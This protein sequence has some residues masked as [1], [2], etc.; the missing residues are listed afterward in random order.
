MKRP[1]LW[2]EA[3]RDDYLGII[4]FIAQENPD[5]AERVADGID[6]AILRLG[7]M[8]VGR[9]GRV[10]GTYEKVVAGLPYI[11]AY[12]IVAQPDGGEMIAVLH[13]IHGARNWPKGEWPEP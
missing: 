9:A 3:A 5:A 11:I 2:A 7:D 10:S 4:R 13:V 12:D 6:Q 1:V 8:A